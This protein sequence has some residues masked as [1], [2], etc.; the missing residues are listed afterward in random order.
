MHFM[1]NKI[2]IFNKAIKVMPNQIQ[3]CFNYLESSINSFLL[4]KIFKGKFIVKYTTLSQKID[5]YH[6]LT[7]IC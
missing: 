7:D 2:N 3:L 4:T 1:P 6:I 5:D